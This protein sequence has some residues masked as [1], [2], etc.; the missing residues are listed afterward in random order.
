M[1]VVF[2]R[3]GAYKT[4]G[5]S[6]DSLY[7]LSDEGKQSI[8]T[9]CKKLKEQNIVPELLFSSPLKRAEETSEIISESFSVSMDLLDELNH[10]N[11]EVLKNL[12]QINAPKTIFFVG[13][14]PTLLG[15]AKE[16]CKDL[17]ITDLKKGAA[18]VLD[19]NEDEKKATFRQAF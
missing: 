5:Y 17:P 14:A 8:Y 16:L 18:I 9:L 19:V 13:H 11:K 2:I 10:F 7:P 3:H 4:E 12:I 15:F 6:D 1:F